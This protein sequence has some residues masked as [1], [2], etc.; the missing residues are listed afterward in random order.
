M[1]LKKIEGEKNEQVINAWA[2]DQ[3]SQWA[4]QWGEK[5]L[6]EIRDKNA[7]LFDILVLHQGLIDKW[8]GDASHSKAVVSVFLAVMKKCFKYVVI[9]TGRGTPANIPLG[10]RVLPFPTLE[11]TLFKMYPEKMVLVDTIM[12][13]LPVAGQN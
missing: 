12:N 4:E 9:T 13:I 7:A 8:L 2:L 3:A 6:K 11:S 5:M 1:D 10:A